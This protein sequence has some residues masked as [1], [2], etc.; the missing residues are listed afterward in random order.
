M[1]ETVGKDRRLPKQPNAPYNMA[2]AFEPDEMDNILYNLEY[3]RKKRR[4]LNKASTVKESN[5]KINKM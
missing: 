2:S 4:I 5:I 3:D 1:V